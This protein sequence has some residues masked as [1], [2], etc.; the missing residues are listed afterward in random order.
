MAKIRA[1]ISGVGAFLPE[2]RLTNEEIS[3]MV[4]TSDEWIMQRIGI[5]ERCAADGKQIVAL[6]EKELD[7]IKGLVK[8]AG[9]DLAQFFEY[10]F[11]VLKA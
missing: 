4:D 6:T 7:R 1:A 5:K 2:Y 9:P 3:T 10:S 8:K 11:T